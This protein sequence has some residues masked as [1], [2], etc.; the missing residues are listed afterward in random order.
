MSLLRR[1]IDWRIQLRDLRVVLAAVVAVFCI[2]GVARAEGSKASFYAGAGYINPKDVDGTVHF[3]GGFRLNVTEALSVEPEFGYWKKSAGVEDF[4]RVGLSD[5]TV[6]ANLVFRPAMNGPV[7]VY[8]GGGPA[9]HLV[10]FSA[11]VVGISDSET[12]TCF[13][14]Q[15]F[16]GAD[17]KLSRPVWL[18]ATARYDIVSK[19]NWSDA[20]EADVS[21]FKVYGGIRVNF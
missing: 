4:L 14:G 3:T 5:A 15:A 18:F 8:L 12:K 2:A 19:A 21:G 17:F 7:G 6:S 16:V 13:G 10:K 9:L 11:S 20:L 1:D